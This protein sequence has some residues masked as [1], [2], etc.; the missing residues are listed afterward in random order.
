ASRQA[1]QPRTQGHGDPVEPTRLDEDRGLARRRPAQGRP[2]GV[3]GLRALPG[4]VRTGLREGRRTDR[5]PLGPERT[6][7]SPSERVPRTG[8]AG[9]ARGRSD[10]RTRPDTPGGEPADQDPRLRPQLD[11]TP[12]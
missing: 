5:L 7:E 3:R 12:R 4:E 1:T 2:E 11:H 6:A 8:H 10:L 9:P